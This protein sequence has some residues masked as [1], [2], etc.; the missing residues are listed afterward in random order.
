MSKPTSSTREV[1]SIFLTLG[2][3]IVSFFGDQPHNNVIQY[4]FY[5]P[6]PHEHTGIA[7]S[8]LSHS[9]IMYYAL[10]YHFVKW[11]RPCRDQW[12]FSF[13]G[14]TILLIHYP[15]AQ[16][17]WVLRFQAGQGLGSLWALGSRLNP[18]L[19]SECN[20][21]LCPVMHGTSCQVCRCGPC[22]QRCAIGRIKQLPTFAG[23][24]AL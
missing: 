10:V 7:L 5:W 3:T 22:T 2:N 14:W 11:L 6:S 13:S 16:A 9:F 1:F 8:S 19:G 4:A 21:H 20:Q 24:S 15:Q 12:I 18:F 23:L 17:S